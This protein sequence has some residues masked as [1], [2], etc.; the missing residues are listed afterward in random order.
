MLS[1]G[2][3]SHTAPRRHRDVLLEHAARAGAAVPLAGARRGEQ[4]LGAR[5]DLRTPMCSSSP[6][7]MPAG[8]CSTMAWHTASPS[9]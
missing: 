6:P 2:S 4:R 7:A 9:G 3:H 1:C 8:G 5:L